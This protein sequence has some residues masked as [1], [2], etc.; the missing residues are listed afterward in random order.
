MISADGLPSAYPVKAHQGDGCRP[1]AL[2]LET[3]VGRS[4]GF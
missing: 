3:S 2:N 1:L 4:F